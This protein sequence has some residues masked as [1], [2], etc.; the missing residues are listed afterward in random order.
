MKRTLTLMLCVVLCLTLVPAAQAADVSP[1][2]PMTGATVQVPVSADIAYSQAFAVLEI[3]N[4]ERAANGLAPL[5]MD[6]GLMETAILRAYETILYWDHTRPNGE[7][8]FTADSRM[9]GENIAAGSRSAERVMERWMNSAGHRSNIL[10]NYKSIGIACIEAAG[11]YYWVQC[12]G[13]SASTAAAKPADT[14]GTVRS[15]AVQCSSEYYHPLFTLSAASLQRGE[16]AKLAVTWESWRDVPLPFSGVTVESSNPAVIQVSGDKITALRAGVSEIRVY[17]GNYAAGAQTF[18][19]TVVKGGFV[20]VPSDEY[21]AKAVDWAVEHNPVITTGTDS[22]HF[23]PDAGCTRAQAVT[24]LWR[25][26]GCPEPNTAASSFTDVERGSYYEKAVRWAVEN[27]ITKGV[28]NAAFAPE[29]TC[30]RAHIV[31]FLMRAQK[32]AP[33][34]GVPSPFVDVPS[35]TWYTEAVLWATENQITNGTDAK[36]FSPDTTCSRAQIVTFIWR[37]TK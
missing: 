28:S 18:T 4:R 30:T 1:A 23:S 24:F 25:A 20:D 19:V 31:T 13:A 27:N 2:A 3:V 10:G 11:E 16:T 12:F 9:N 35:S 8:C 5:T 17:Y 29:D 6:Q 36:H 26:A 7:L 14:T 15:I 21:Y 33:S 32:G 37:S 22:T 34:A